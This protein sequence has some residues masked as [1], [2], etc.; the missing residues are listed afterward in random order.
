MFERERLCSEVNSSERGRPGRWPAGVSPACAF[1]GETPADQRA[2]R[3][4]SEK[5]TWR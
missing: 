3:P 1:A 5:R 2:G 4:R